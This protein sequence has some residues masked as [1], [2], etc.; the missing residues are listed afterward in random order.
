MRKSGRTVDR[1]AARACATSS[2]R[3]APTMTCLAGCRR[4]ELSRWRT[5]QGRMRFGMRGVSVGR[6]GDLS[7]ANQFS[8]V[9][10]FNP[11]ACERTKGSFFAVQASLNSAT[12]AVMDVNCDR[13]RPPRKGARCDT[14]SPTEPAAKR[15]RGISRRTNGLTLGSRR[16]GAVVR[17]A[18]RG[19]RPR[20][21]ECRRGGREKKNRFQRIG[22]PKSQE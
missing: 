6:A 12:E 16:A 13:R 7:V 3:G 11:I 14:N 9:V 20:V 18:L 19:V 10:L 17:L 8:S 2:K 15:E 21:K 22:C 5:R 1:P 4:L